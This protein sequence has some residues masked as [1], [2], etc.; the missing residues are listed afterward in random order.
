MSEVRGFRTALF[1]DKNV[2][3][4]A[5]SQPQSWRSNVSRPTYWAKSVLLWLTLL[6]VEPLSARGALV[7]L[8]SACFVLRVHL[9]MTLFWRRAISWREVVLETCFIVPLSFWSFG[10]SCTSDM[11]SALDLAWFALFLVGTWLN[12]WP[13]WERHLWKT[14]PRHSAARVGKLYTGSLFRFARHINYTGEVVSFV[15]LALLTGS[16]W[17][18]W[19]PL[20]MGAGMATFSIVSGRTIRTRDFEWLLTS[21][22]SQ[23]ARLAVGDRVLPGAAV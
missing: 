1:L 4:L 12:V 5:T 11:L 17:T 22:S 13:E 20:C 8:S 2:R 10:V 14:D 6:L 9:Q 18:L 19:V 23:S 3:R 16:W 15:G 21:T 7:W